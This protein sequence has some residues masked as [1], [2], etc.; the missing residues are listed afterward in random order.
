MRNTVVVAAFVAAL[1]CVGSAGPLGTAAGRR[2]RTAAGQARFRRRDDS[3]VAAAPRTDRAAIRPR[4]LPRSPRQF[5]RSNGRDEFRR[6]EFRPGATRV[7]IQERDRQ[8]LAGHAPGQRVLADRRRLHGVRQTARGSP[9]GSS[10]S[11]GSTTPGGLPVSRSLSRSRESLSPRGQPAQA[12]RGAQ[13]H[14]ALRG[15]RADTRSTAP[16]S[17]S[18]PIRA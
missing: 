15:P 5:R 11:S 16:C 4:G 2:R 6:S 17:R 3:G 14:G 12:V 1:T 10:R 8:N 18:K 13:L 7:V 9:R